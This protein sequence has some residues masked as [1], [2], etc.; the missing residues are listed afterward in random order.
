M[1]EVTTHTEKTRSMW[2]PIGLGIGF[3]MLLCLLYGA[4]NIVFIGHHSLATTKEV[5]WGLFIINYAWAISSIGLSYIAS[6]G[7]VL[8]IRQFDVIGRRALYL[9]LIIVIAGA[10]SVA[11]D[12]AS[13]LHAPFLLLT[14]HFSAPMGVVAVSISLYIVLIAAELFLVIKRGHHDILVKVVAVAAFAAA[15]IVH[16]YHGAIFGL[17]YS[18]SFWYGPYYPIY[19]L[20]SALFASSAMIIFVTVTT[21]K[22]MRLQMSERLKES[23]SLIGRML[24]YLLVIAL[25]FLYWKVVAG[26]YAHKEEAYML[27]TGNFAFNF[28]VGEMLLTYLLPIGMLVYSRFKDYNKMAIAGLMVFAGLYIG[29]YDF[30]IAGQLVPYVGFTPFDSDLGGSLSA[31]ASYTPS[32]TEITYT[33]GLLG[34]I[35]TGYMLGIKYLPLHTDELEGVEELESVPLVTVYRPRRKDKDDAGVKEENKQ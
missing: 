28:W 4:A 25:F 31:F 5:P 22:V 9:A 18:R 33:I 13:P 14:T 7:I 6:F 12:L 1:M 32:L 29:R 34:F 15:V 3:A 23:L 35:W 17:P 21:Y 16:S 19:F 20:L 2:F 26:H 11:A 24:V 30:I 8:G 10:M 27:L